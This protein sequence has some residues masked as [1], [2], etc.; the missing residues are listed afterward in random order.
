MTIL[1]VTNDEN[2]SFLRERYQF[3][4][5]MLPGDFWISGGSVVE[6]LQVAM[7]TSFGDRLHHAKDYDLFFPTDLD[8]EYAKVKLCLKGGKIL[9]ETTNAVGILVENCDKIFELIKIYHSTPEEVIESFDFVHC[10]TI[11]TRKKI[12]A[13][14]GVIGNIVDKR[15]VFT[16]A[17]YKELNEEKIGKTVHRIRKY[18]RDGFNLTPDSLWYLLDKLIVELGLSQHETDQYVLAT[19]AETEALKSE[20]SQTFRSPPIPPTIKYDS[21]W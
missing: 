11:V 10:Q 18:A 5:D 20:V 13:E 1:D 12:L 9:Y 2:F 19:N 14:Q 7:D 6:S 21:D 17:F 8:L 4:F 3:I 16:L 15:L